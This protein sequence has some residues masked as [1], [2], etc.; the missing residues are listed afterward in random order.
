[1][2]ISILVEEHFLLKRFI[3]RAESQKKLFIFIGL[4]FEESIG[5]HHIIN[6]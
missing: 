5:Q 3:L 4:I 2:I 6:I 1:M